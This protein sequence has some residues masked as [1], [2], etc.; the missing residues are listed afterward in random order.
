M[1]ELKNPLLRS[2]IDS[3]KAT[4]DKLGNSFTEEVILTQE[5]DLSK[6]GYASEKSSFENYNPYA[7]GFHQFYK[8]SDWISYEQ[9][10]IT[11]VQNE[12]HTNQNY[13]NKFAAIQETLYDEIAKLKSQIK[14]LNSENSQKNFRHC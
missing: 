13:L 3:I 6:S 2:K 10:S 14:D 11:P 4:F 9:E 7:P 1:D 5:S 8:S 12:S